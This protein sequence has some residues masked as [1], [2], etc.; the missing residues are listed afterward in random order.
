MP[1]GR[2]QL[3]TMVFR[4]EPSGFIEWMRSPL[5]SR[6]NNLPER[7]TPDEAFI[8]VAWSTVMDCPFRVTVTPRT[9]APGCG[10]REF[11]GLT[12]G[13]FFVFLSAGRRANLPSGRPRR[14]AVRRSR[15]R[16]RLARAPCVGYW[17]A[18]ERVECEGLGGLR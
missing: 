9:R 1:S 2:W 17:S 6:R 5:N 14:K 4:S 11:P 10:D 16:R 12:R 18:G 8:L 13:P 7:V 15:C 3:V